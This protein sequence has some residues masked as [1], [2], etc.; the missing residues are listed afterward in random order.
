MSKPPAL[1]DALLNNAAKSAEARAERA[2]R[3]LTEARDVLNTD[4]KIASD[5]VLTLELENQRLQRALAEAQAKDE[6]VPEPSLLELHAQGGDITA[7][8]QSEV[9]PLL[10]DGLAGMFEA[11]GATNFLEIEGFH[12]RLG[13]LLLNIQRKTGMKPSEKL[14]QVE[15]ERDRAQAALRKVRGHTSYMPGAPYTLL[16]ELLQSIERIVEAAL[17]PIAPTQE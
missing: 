4:L 17:T 2:E 8:F 11:H 13:A 16:A 6:P 14:K 9:F 1:L 12:P 15:A 5:R 10:I 7:R 3:E